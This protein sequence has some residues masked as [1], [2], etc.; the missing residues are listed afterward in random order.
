LL[1]ALRYPRVLSGLILAYMG[2]SGRLIAEDERSVLSPRYP[3]YRPALTALTAD[4]LPR[5]PAVLGGVNPRLASAA[6]GPL[7]TDGWLLTRHGEALVVCPEGE[8][9]V[10]AAFEEFATGFDVRE[11]LGEIPVP[12]LVVAGRHDEIVPIDHCERLAAGLPHATYVVLEDSGH[13]DV[14]SA[15][16]DGERYLAAV[17]RFLAGLPRSIAPEPPQD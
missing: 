1:S 14:D 9:R 13:G 16:T 2:P 6:W 17:R 5:R 10:W 3:P 8:A 15:S 11:R 4:V 12:T 7:G